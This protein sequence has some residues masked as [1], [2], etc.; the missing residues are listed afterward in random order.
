MGS[1][2]TR[3]AWEG[4]H[5]H[6]EEVGVVDV[7]LDRVEEVLHAPR[8]GHVPVDEVLVA[9]A[10]DHLRVR[11]WPMCEAPRLVLG[12]DSMETIPIPGG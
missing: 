12:T 6:D 4:P 5:L 3:R 1:G 7:Q 10:N 9:P 2:S 11:S 8:L